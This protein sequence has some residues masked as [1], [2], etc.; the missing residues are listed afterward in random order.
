MI[1]T[2]NTSFAKVNRVR[3]I[4]NL[5]YLKRKRNFENYVC[6]AFGK[7][8]TKLY[9]DQEVEFLYYLIPSVDELIEKLMDIV[10]INE[11]TISN[12]TILKDSAPQKK[13]HLGVEQEP[14]ATKS[15]KNELLKR[16][17]ELESIIEDNLDY[18]NVQELVYCYGKATEIFSQEEGSEFMIFTVKTQS[19]LSRPDIQAVLDSNRN[20]PLLDMDVTDHEKLG[21]YEPGKKVPEESAKPRFKFTGSDDEEEI[22][23]KINPGDK[24][25]SGGSANMDLLNLD[26]G[27]ADTAQP[28]NNQTPPKS[29]DLLSLDLLTGGDKVSKTAD[30]LR[31]R[32]KAGDENSQQ[33]PEDIPQQFEDLLDGQFDHGLDSTPQKATG[34]SGFKDE[35]TAGHRSG[36]DMFESPMH[37]SKLSRK[38]SKK[39]TPIQIRKDSYSDEENKFVIG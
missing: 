35:Q 18:K 4:K 1:R 30:K 36:Y 10:V 17:G 37:D 22:E 20:V 9:Q 39:G 8:A 28:K 19:L 11:A 34:D 5:L 13:K 16:I 3:H 29:T 26:I 32:K 38:S 25:A 21:D 27:E 23:E 14:P 2:A 31:K 6:F 12:N 24:K 15:D 7:K 33:Q